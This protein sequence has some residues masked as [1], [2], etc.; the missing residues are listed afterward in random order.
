MKKSASLK[1]V[2]RR[3]FRKEMIAALC[4]VLLLLVVSFGAITVMKGMGKTV[5][6][7]DNNIIVS[8]ID[9]DLVARL[10]VS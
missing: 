1:L 4:S 10:A 8:S 5:V 2:K 9:G 7:Q 6:Y 3:I